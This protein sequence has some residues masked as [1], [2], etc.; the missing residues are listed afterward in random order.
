MEI[1]SKKLTSI[2]IDKGLQVPDYSLAALPPSGSGNNV[3]FLVADIEGKAWNFAC[4]TKTG[5]NTLMKP[6]FSKDWFAFARQWG[7]RSGATIAFYMEIDQATGAQYKIKVRQ[8]WGAW[9]LS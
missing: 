1:F 8:A 7:L 2:D 9:V 6:V 4:T 3:E 5:R